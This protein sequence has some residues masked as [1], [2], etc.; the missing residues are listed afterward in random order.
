MIS[1]YTSP[2]GAHDEDRYTEEISNALD[3]PVTKSAKNT[4]LPAC[5]LFMLRSPLAG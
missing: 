4:R 2:G 1:Q 5:A 3:H